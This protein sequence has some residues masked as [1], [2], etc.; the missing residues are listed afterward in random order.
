MPKLLLAAILFTIHTNCIEMQ[1]VRASF[2]EISSSEE[3]EAFIESAE[4]IE[5]KNAT[6]YIASAIMRRAEFASWPLKKWS[7]FQEGKKMLEDFIS[8]NPNDVESKY[9]RFLVQS[10]VPSLLNY[11]EDLN[12]D[13]T[14]I[15]AN[16]DRT[17]LSTE[18]KNIISET[19]VSILKKNK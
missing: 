13:A 9:L 11:S 3:L 12:S 2:H 14:Y 16:L 4:K 5:C 17:E 8:K 1:A 7:Y 15:L 19:V 10:E 6:P 18:Y